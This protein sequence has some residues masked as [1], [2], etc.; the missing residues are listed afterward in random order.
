MWIARLVLYFSAFLLILL[1]A[2]LLLLF[3]LDFGRF[4]PE[5][6]ALASD[7][8]GRSFRI[9]GPLRV[10]LDIREGARLHAS[11]VSL[12]GVE[13]GDYPELVS[14]KS[15]D[16]EVDIWSALGAGPIIIERVALGGLRVNLEE[17]ASGANNW[18][19][20]DADDEELPAEEPESPEVE[21]TRIPIWPAVVQIDDAR[22]VYSRPGQI[23][24]LEIALASLSKRVDDAGEVAVSLVGTVSDKPL[25]V[26]LEPG[27]LD[28]LLELRDLAVAL[29]GQ[30]G[31]IQFDGNFAL[32]DALNPSRPRATLN[33]DGPSVEYLLATLMLPPLTEGPL[34]LALTV[35]PEQSEMAVD[36]K[37]EFG[38]FSLSA[39]GTFSDLREFENIDLE[40]I[41]DGP[42]A[43]TLSGVFGPELLPHDPFAVRAVLNRSGADIL[44]PEFQLTLG[45]SRL[46]AEARLANFP[47]PNGMAATARLDIPELAQFGEPLD[48]PPE[49]SGP[50]ALTAELKARGDNSGAL[51]G[52]RGS[53]LGMA[54][55]ADGDLTSEPD[56]VDSNLQLSVAAPSINSLISMAGLEATAETP[57][58]LSLA[59][60]RIAGGVALQDVLAT[61]GDT[62]LEIAGT[63]ADDP[64][65]S[66]TRISYTLAVPALRD[67]LS[68]FGIDGSQIPRGDL[69]AGGA[70]RGADKRL[71]IEDTTAE[72]AGVN[73]SVD[74][75]VSL[76]SVPGGTLDIA[77][78]GNDLASL[79]PAEGLP[80]SLSNRFTLDAGISLEGDT[81]AVEEAVFAIDETRLALSSSLNLTDPMA[82]GK[83]R[84]AGN[85]PDLLALLASPG[86]MEPAAPLPLELD[87]RGH[88]EGQQLVLDGVEMKVG[89]GSLHID[90]NLSAPNAG[91]SRLSLKAD[92][93]SL[94]DWS[95]FAGQ[96]L[97]DLP[98]HLDLL[99]VGE[100]ETYRLDRFTGTLGE[101]D[102]S[103]QFSARLGGDVPHIDLALKSRLIDVTPFMPPPEEAEPGAADPAPAPTAQTDPAEKMIPDTPVSLEP[104]AVVDAD[105]D[106]YIEELKVEAHR[107]RGVQLQAVLREGELNVNKAALTTPRGGNL[108]AAAVLRPQA[109]GAE[110]IAR[111]KGDTL[112]L[113]F[114]A[115][116]DEE[117]QALPLYTLDLAMASGGQTVRDL[118]GSTNGYLRIVAG[119]GQLQ[120]GALRFVTNDFIAHLVDTVNPFSV[121]DPYT[122][123]S[124][125]NVLV[126]IEDGLV[127]GEPIFVLQTDRLNIF[128]DS[129]VDLKTEQLEL[130]FQTVPQQGLGISLT[131]LV[132]PYVMVD[133]TLASPSLSL[134]TQSAAVQGVAAVATGGLSILAFSLKDRFFSE[135]DPCGQSLVEGDAGLRELE[136]KYARKDGTGVT[137]PP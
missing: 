37:S 114:P 123:V 7:A 8:L 129:S 50:M 130:T 96:E 68:G 41:A 65:S 81:L 13:A 47:D 93:R 49:F 97:P 16:V 44:V 74:G 94:Q 33:L 58:A 57:L 21:R 132:N 5:L 101:S 12:A 56:F 34:Q 99:L 24:P 9:D 98:V 69:V 64:V 46:V 112:N 39:D 10:S 14:F 79:V 120:G 84:V 2:G 125:A 86:S 83:F 121:Q 117:L 26:D 105:I 4:K 126:S 54:L 122:K 89:E 111:M 87:G 29:R 3:N 63:V 36:L 131:T 136:A 32:A 72:F 59:A 15:L 25:R 134:D 113:G 124:C 110:L 137:L 42:D 102:I 106:V 92:S 31:Q 127:L 118:A 119:P 35:A 6:E 108:K 100:G 53:A 95:V 104:L 51:L 91:L 103:G 75:L 38:E 48:L 22:A 28:S 11:Q 23:Q 60:R 135:E 133:G 107:M 18:T 73:V 109:D 76:E 90:G 115:T 52:A 40:L 88:W 67:T 128:A 66:G 70:L 61:V 27:G 71:H 80:P 17:D 1:C 82:A 85:S 116:T 55:Q 19:L 20:F 30:L 45:D 78:R 43:G 62:R 77:I